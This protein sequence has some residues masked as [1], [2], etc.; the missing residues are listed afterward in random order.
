MRFLEKDPNATAGNAIVFIH[1][2]LLAAIAF[3]KADRVI[4]ALS[5]HQVL[6]VG[7][8]VKLLLPRVTR[9]G[10]RDGVT[11]SQ[12]RSVFVPPQA[13][14]WNWTSSEADSVYV[15]KRTLLT[16]RRSVLSWH[17]IW[18]HCGVSTVSSTRIPNSRKRRCSGVFL[19]NSA[20]TRRASRPLVTISPDCT[21]WLDRCAASA[22]SI[23]QRSRMP[24]V[25]STRS[26]PQK[27]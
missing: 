16:H 6:W 2:L 23:A 8:Q 15:K 20:T 17:I 4:T 12:Y 19:R 3:C 10:S 22:T 11:S 7:D 25:C 1:S 5:Q 13:R 27:T 24:S 9:M 14:L 18:R 26:A 21:R